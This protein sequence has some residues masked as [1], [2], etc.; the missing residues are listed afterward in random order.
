MVVAVEWRGQKADRDED[1]KGGGEAGPASVDNPFENISH[2]ER[3]RH[4]L[5][6][7]GGRGVK[8]SFKMGCS[9]MCSDADRKL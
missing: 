9:R 5:V 7:G 8:M 6:A 2:E 1:A 4:E 3:Q